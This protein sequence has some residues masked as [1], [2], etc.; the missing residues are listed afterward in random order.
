MILL[1]TNVISE[2]LRRRPDP[3]VSRWLDAQRPA[4]LFLC[5][6]VIAELHY[7]AQLLPA[8]ARRTHLE[9]TIKRIEETF[10][11]RTLPFDR[12]AAHEYG[13]IIAHRDKMGRASGTMDGLIAAIAKVHGAMVATRDGRG[14]DGI[15]LEIINPFDPL[16][17]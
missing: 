9:L 1:D 17:P 7:G 4:D 13:R 11:D 10:S 12:A 2:G 6:P 5:M 15:G 3:H 8:G 16:T 14:F